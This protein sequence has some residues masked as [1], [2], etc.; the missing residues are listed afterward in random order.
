MV[1]RVKNQRCHPPAPARKLNAAPGLCASTRLKNGVTSRHSPSRNAE[2]T[3]HLVARSR[4]MT[5]TLTPSQRGQPR[6]AASR[7]PAH[8]A[9]SLE[10]LNA[11]PADGRVA[12][13]DAHVVAP[14]PAALAFRVRARLHLDR[15]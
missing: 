10:V 14:M 6:R 9:R 7:M 13:V 15:D 1:M 12:R 11:A 3:H 8:L 5:A 4:A 2:L